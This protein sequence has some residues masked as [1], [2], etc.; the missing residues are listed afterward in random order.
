[1]GPLV[2]PSGG[3]ARERRRG[4]DAFPHPLLRSVQG[5]RTARVRGPHPLSRLPRC[6]GPPR[7]PHPSTMIRAD[8][9]VTDIGELATLARGP[10]PRIGKAAEELGL[11]TGRGARRRRG[12]FRL[13]R[14]RTRPVSS[15][16]PAP[17][18]PSALGERRGRGTRVRGRPHPRPLRRRPRVRASAQGAWG[19]IRRDRSGRR[20]AFTRPFGRLGPPPTRPCS[21]RPRL[22]SDA[23]EAGEPL[24][25]R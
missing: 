12:A 6:P 18:R 4:V 11:H 2:G 25:S 22:D 13:G 10:V 23:W 24:R 17:G 14:T 20:E 15:R 8:L 21:R 3:R 5:A 9:L 19:R 16:P 7:P 1:M